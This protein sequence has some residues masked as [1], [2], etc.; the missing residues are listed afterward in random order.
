[1]RQYIKFLK[2]L[3]VILIVPSLYGMVSDANNNKR[4]YSL[5]EVKI[6]DQEAS[7]KKAKIDKSYKELRHGLVID[8]NECPNFVEI[9]KQSFGNDKDITKDEALS[10]VKEAKDILKANGADTNLL[11]CNGYAFINGLMNVTHNFD[12]FSVGEKKYKA[13]QLCKEFGVSVEEIDAM[14]DIVN[15]YPR[16]K[17]ILNSN[18]TDNK[19]KPLIWSFWNETKNLKKNSEISEVLQNYQEKTHINN[20]HREK[21]LSESEYIKSL[22]VLKVD[23]STLSFGRKGFFESFKIVKEIIIEKTNHLLEQ[24][25]KYIGFFDLNDGKEFLEKF[26]KLKATNPID[27]IQCAEDL[28]SKYTRYTHTECIVEYLYRDQLEPLNMVTVRDPCKFC[29]EMAAKITP[30][31]PNRYSVIISGK[32]YLKYDSNCSFCNRKKRRMDKY[33]RHKF[34]IYPECKHCEDS[35]ERDRSTLVN[36]HL[37]LVQLNLESSQKN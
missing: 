22:N 8:L 27:Y 17:R 18:K 12:D 15:V 33:N 13:K 11:F 34:V 4:S 7:S 2:F 23:M 21:L 29:E 6:E 25:G 36:H 3:W 14:Y 32:R 10:L 30:E 24:F 31:H 26:E 35:R 28:C 19:I 1:M 20:W 9:I 37:K 5:S 16:L